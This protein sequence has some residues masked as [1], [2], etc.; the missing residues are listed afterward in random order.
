MS[1][2]ETTEKADVHADIGLRFCHEVFVVF[3]GLVGTFDT[4]C[5]HGHVSTDI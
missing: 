4:L 1:K 2:T 5:V 3:R